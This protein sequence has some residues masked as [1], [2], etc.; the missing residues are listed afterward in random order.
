MGL[1]EAANVPF[2]IPA[3]V[4]ILILFRGDDH[5]G[6]RLDHAKRYGWTGENIAF[7]RRA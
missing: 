6:A 3:G 2:R 4:R 7:A 5:V 1:A